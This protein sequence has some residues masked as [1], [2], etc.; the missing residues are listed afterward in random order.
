M[1]IEPGL[2]LDVYSRL[3]SLN[4]R[5]WSTHGDENY[6]IKSCNLLSAHLAN[7]PNLFAKNKLKIIAK[8]QDLTSA[9]LNLLY[10]NTNTE[11]NLIECLIQDIRETQLKIQRS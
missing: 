2:L 8:I 7:N 4:E 9:C 5:I 6:L 1:N 11:K 10:T 3:I